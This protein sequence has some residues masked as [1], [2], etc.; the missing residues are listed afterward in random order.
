VGAA[1][2]ERE[3]A[4]A[5]HRRPRRHGLQEA[6]APAGGS[7]AGGGGWSGHVSIEAGTP[8]NGL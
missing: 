4:E 8:E 5:R 2:D 1:D 3:D 7:E 6:S